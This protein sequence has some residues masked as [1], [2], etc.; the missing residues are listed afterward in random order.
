MLWTLL[1]LG[2]AL[3]AS[4]DIVWWRTAGGTVVQLH[5]TKECSLV[6]YDNQ[7]GIAISWQGDTEHIAVQ[8]D[9]LSLADGQT[10]PMNVQVGHIVLGVL[11]AVVVNN[12]YVSAVSSQ[13]I[14]PL[15]PSADKIIFQV[16]DI[17]VQ[18]DLN[19][20]KMPALLEGVKK[21]RSNQR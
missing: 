3:A 2:V 21:C 12:N 19:R 5:D 20:S 15:L 11:P 18:Y 9:R 1:G 13:P 6:L 4:N 17:E 8:D 14:E 7:H 16:G 10:V